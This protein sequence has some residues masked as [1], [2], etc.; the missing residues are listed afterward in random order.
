MSAE[1]NRLNRLGVAWLCGSLRGT[2][3]RLAEGTAEAENSCSGPYD[4]VEG[5]TRK[6]PL[7]SAEMRFP[8]LFMEVTTGFPGRGRIFP[9]LVRKTYP[10]GKDRDWSMRLSSSCWPSESNTESVVT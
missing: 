5:V 1:K 10:A 2:Y 7:K 4:F 9:G 8:N 3:R 6:T